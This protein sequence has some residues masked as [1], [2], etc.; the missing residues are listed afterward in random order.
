[1]KCEKVVSVKVTGMTGPGKILAQGGTEPGS[2][3][4]E[5]HALAKRPSWPERCVRD[6]V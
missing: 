6:K 3:A 5:A 4:L 2:A 1:M